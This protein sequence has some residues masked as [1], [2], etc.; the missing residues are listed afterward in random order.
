[1]I[2][3][4]LHMSA[5]GFYIRKHTQPI[6]SL[7]KSEVKVSGTPQPPTKKGHMTDS[8]DMYHWGWIW[9]PPVAREKWGRVWGG[10]FQGG[11]LWLQQASAAPTVIPYPH[12]LC[13]PP[14]SPLP[15]SRSLAWQT[16][17]LPG[18]ASKWQACHPWGT[19]R[20]LASGE[21]IPSYTLK[22][23]NPG[24]WHLQRYTVQKQRR[25]AGSLR[26]GL[27]HLLTMEGLSPLLPLN[28]CT[29]LDIIW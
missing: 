19:G 8:G 18:S 24:S 23:A 22:G 10:C 14:L 26:W 4:Y 6:E 12:H 21:L 2:P 3:V 1:M 15:P 16:G 29:P 27:Q 5:P 11:P 7:H 20:G 13:P 25:Q 9:T 28:T 17:S